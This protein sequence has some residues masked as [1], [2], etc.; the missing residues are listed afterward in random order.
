MSQSDLHNS[1][2]LTADLR[3]NAPVFQCT[4]AAAADK[5]QAEVCVCERS[6][7]CVCVSFDIMTQEEFLWLKQNEVCGGL[8]VPEQ[9]T[10]VRQDRQRD[11]D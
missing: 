1:V 6:Y 9:P 5:T 11:T 4:R 2:S 10:G 3:A 7:V 8:V